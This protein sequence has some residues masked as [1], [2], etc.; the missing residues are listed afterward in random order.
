MK[1]LFFDLTMGAAGDMLCAALLELCPDRAAVVSAL[2]AIGIPGVT[3]RLEPREKCGVMGSHFS[4]LVDG[5]EEKPD[6]PPEHHH[7]HHD[8]HDIRALIVSLQLDDAVKADALAVYDLLAAAEAKAQASPPPSLHAAGV[9]VSRGVVELRGE[10]LVGR[11][12]ARGVP[13]TRTAAE[14]HGPELEHLLLG[15]HHAVGTPSAAMP[16]PA[17]ARDG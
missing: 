8:L 13:R 15:V 11:R 16:E 7:H 2:N 4:V 10:E 14:L 6:E 17:I 12:V 9:G 1:T 3:L 5:E